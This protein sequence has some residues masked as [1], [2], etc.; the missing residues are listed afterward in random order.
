MVSHNPRWLEHSNSGQA[1]CLGSKVKTEE[2]GEQI[3]Q[4]DQTIVCCI[5]S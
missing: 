3:T 5:V 4:S 2:N 1:R